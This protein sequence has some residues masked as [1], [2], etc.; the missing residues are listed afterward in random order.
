[1]PEQ[2]IGKVS[3]YFA[4][5]MV[6]AIELTSTLK[7]GDTIHIRGASTDMT[8]TVGSMQI[9]RANVELADAG[10]SIG[11]KVPD[12]ARSGDEVFLVTP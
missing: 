8:L 7:V 2:S 3:K 9:D 5:P 6:A 10:A 4:K 11:V 12:R 1:M